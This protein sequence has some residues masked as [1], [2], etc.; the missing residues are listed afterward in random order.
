ME[1]ITRFFIYREPKTKPG[2]P[3]TCWTYRVFSCLV[4][5]MLLVLRRVARHD[6][7]DAP[8]SPPGAYLPA[9]FLRS[10]FLYAVL[11]LLV[12]HHD[13]VQPAHPD[14]RAALAHPV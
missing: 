5:V 7:A 8:V 3:S 9:A 6:R 14:F 13:R 1:H 11:V 2:K 4:V 12:S 10:S